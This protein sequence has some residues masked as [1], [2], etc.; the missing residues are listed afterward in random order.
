MKLPKILRI[1]QFYLFITFQ[2]ST[3]NPIGGNG[4]GPETAAGDHA[5]PSKTTDNTNPEANE[6]NTPTSSTIKSYDYGA[7]KF[8]VTTQKSS[9]WETE[10]DLDDSTLVGDFDFGENVKEGTTEDYNNDDIEKVMVS[11][12]FQNKTKSRF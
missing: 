11:R 2:V 10:I 4:N 5:Y 8:V 9:K 7:E 6:G 1:V 3:G 12:S